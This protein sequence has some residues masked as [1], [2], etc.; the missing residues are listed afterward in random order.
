MRGRHGWTRRALVVVAALGGGLARASECDPVGEGFVPHVEPARCG[1][2]SLPE[3]TTCGVIHNAATPGD[4]AACR[5]R[6]PFVRLPATGPVRDAVPAVLLPGGPGQVLLYRLAE[7]EQT[8]RPWRA[9]RDLIVLDPRGGGSSTPRLHGD[10][11]WRRPRSTPARQADAL[12]RRGIDL[13]AFRTERLV[14]DVA[15]LARSVPGGRLHVVGGSFGTRWALALAALHPEVVSSLA[16]GAPVPPSVSYLDAGQARLGEVLDQVFERC[17][18]DARCSE[19]VP[20][21]WGLLAAQIA[22][23]DADPARVAGGPP[24]DGAGLVQRILEGAKQGAPM[25]SLPWT[26]RDLAAG[27]RSALDR[28]SDPAPPEGVVPL[29]YHL[30]VCA[31]ELPFAP[32]TPSGVPDPRLPGLFDPMPPQRDLCATLGVRP[33]DPALRVMPKLDVPVLLLTGGLDPLGGPPWASLALE[34][35]AN[36][37]SWV[38][39]GAGHAVLRTPCAGEMLG[40]FLADPTDV[41]YPACLMSAELT[42]TPP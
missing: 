22:A 34:S 32:A 6:V 35:T 12:R 33:S 25:T 3:G 2:A 8:T 11:R 16:L 18:L 19:D 14:D 36:G 26:L 23:L 40:R 21:P 27:D 41:I 38:D 29:L 5:V 13:D 20:D 42:L 30:I 1:D 37:V 9:A 39:P 15:V 24:V 4:P 7:V 10:E 31:D 28:L 17:I